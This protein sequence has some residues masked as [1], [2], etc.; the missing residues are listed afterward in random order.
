M[1]G[2]QFTPFAGGE[3]DLGLI[4]AFMSQPNRLLVDSH[5]RN[6]SLDGLRG[7]AILLVIVF[8]FA[9]DALTPQSGIAERLL[10]YVPISGW[11]GVDLFF[12]LSGFLITGILLDAKHQTCRRYFQDFYIKRVFRILPLYYLLCFMFFVVMPLLSRG[13]IRPLSTAAWYWLHLSNFFQAAGGSAGFLSVSWSLAVEEQFYLVWPLVVWYLKPRTLARLCIAAIFAAFA[14]RCALAFSGVHA[15]AIYQLTPCRIDCLAVGAWIAI[16]A[17]TPEAKNLVRWANWA[18][19]VSA[20]GLFGVIM[21]ALV[22]TNDMLTGLTFHN[23]WVFTLGMTLNA[24]FFGF[25][26]IRLLASG[27]ETLMHRVFMNRILRDFGKYS[28]CM[29]L[30]H[31]LIINYF[32]LKLQPMLEHHFG[33]RAALFCGLIITCVS[34]YIIGAL[35]WRFFEAPMIAM[36]ERFIPKAT[37][38]AP[39]LA[40]APVV[41]TPVAETTIQLGGKPEPGR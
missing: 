29:Y 9:N 34:V 40:E 15:V 14:T 7:L 13:E 3:G 5:H 21:P 19:L 2:L 26:L 27:K 28:Y 8:K 24:V 25:L 31:M 36:R 4:E 18:L 6:D 1:T 22:M 23:P 39:V 16:G 41:Q 35:S 12:V 17:R 30:T 10:L 20:T 32:H 33:L 38:P 11:S 37:R